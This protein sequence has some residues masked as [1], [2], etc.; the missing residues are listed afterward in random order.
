[1]DSLNF[2]REALLQARILNFEPRAPPRQP[3]TLGKTSAQP[4]ASPPPPRPPKRMA[5]QQQHL[6]PLV[7]FPRSQ[8][9][10]SM[11]YCER[12]SVH[13]VVQITQEPTMQVAGSCALLDSYLSPLM[14]SVFGRHFL[15]LWGS[16]LLCVR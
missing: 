14:R 7:F 8:L 12:A 6:V 4:R 3:C 11:G 2:L 13:P 1:M 16:S 10:H 5:Q 15:G 9:T